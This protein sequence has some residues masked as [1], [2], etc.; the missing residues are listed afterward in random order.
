MGSDRITVVPKLADLT[1]VHTL[2]IKST[3]EYKVYGPYGAPGPYGTWKVE[4]IWPV[5]YV[6]KSTFDDQSMSIG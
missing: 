2:V 4:T 5:D 3:H 1:Y 6:F